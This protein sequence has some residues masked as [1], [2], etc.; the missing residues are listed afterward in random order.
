MKAKARYST[1][2]PKDFPSVQEF[3]KTTATHNLLSQWVDASYTLV[4]ELINKYY[5]SDGE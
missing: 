1:S 2:L 4:T 5:T 3:I